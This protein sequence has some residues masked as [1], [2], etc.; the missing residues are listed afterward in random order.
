M[1][2]EDRTS[3][4]K[5]IKRE[6]KNFEHFQMQ[7]EFK[8]EYF[9]FSPLEFGKSIKHEISIEFEMDI[10]QVLL[11]NGT[12]VIDPVEMNIPPDEFL[13]SYGSYLE[14]IC[15]VAKSEA[16]TSYYPSYNAP[17]DQKFGD[18]FST[19]AQIASDIGIK[20]Y[21]LIHGNLDYY[22]SRDPN[23]QMFQSGGFPVEGYVCPNQSRYWL[24]LSEL[25]KEVANAPIDGILLKNFHFPRDTTCFCDNCR[26][27]FSNIA[28]LDRDFSIEQLKRNER[29]FSRWKQFR[30]ESIAKMVSSVISSV[31]QVKKVTVMPEIMFDPKTQYLDGALQHF[32][33]GLENLRK[34]S[35]HLLIHLF[36]WTDEL[37]N[38]E[39]EIAQFTQAL[40]PFQEI[41]ESN[42][43]SVFVWGINEEKAAL[44]EKLKDAIRSE[45]LF[46]QMTIPSTLL[47]RRSLHLGLGV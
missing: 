2:S 7:G 38:T 19:F 27:E 25:A 23:F 17:K 22:L 28:M 12:L 16:G 3:H 37:P 45:N 47:S 35:S 46:Y 39:E 42:K 8:P 32:G 6:T 14:K 24:Y 18:Y 13:A 44:A 43:T 21:A 20:T 1:K 30:A 4:F 36:P 33:Q 40:V 31:H 34:V 9:A 11:K 26:R 41:M 5:T 15:L 10:R 29:I